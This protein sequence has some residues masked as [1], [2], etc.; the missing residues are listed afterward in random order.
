VFLL[1][2]FLVLCCW[3]TFCKDPPQWKYCSKTCLV[4]INM[5]GS[6]LGGVNSIPSKPVLVFVQGNG[7]FLRDE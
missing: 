1:L 4:F 3:F 7:K 2:L 5:T 6:G